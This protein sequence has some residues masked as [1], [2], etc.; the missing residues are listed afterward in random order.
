MSAPVEAPSRPLEE[1]EAEALIE[2]ARRRARRR[3]FGYAAVLVLAALLGGG[4]YLGFH[5]GGDGGS[6]SKGESSSNGGAGAQQPSSHARE[7][8]VYARRCPGRGLDALPLTRAA[9][10]SARTIAQQRV[11]P[12]PRVTTTVRPASNAGAR[13]SEVTYMCGPRVARRTVV[14][15]T[16][17]HRYDHGPNKSA[18]L[19]Q[20]AILVSRFQDG[21]HLWY[22]EH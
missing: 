12:S 3:R 8:S 1:D 13:G 4:L 7:A 18:S 22:W 2:E 14:V 11:G 17:D 5:G 10:T 21:Y 19:A 20:H 9:Q 16:W 6:G 15:F